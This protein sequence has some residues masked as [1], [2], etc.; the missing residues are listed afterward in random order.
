MKGWAAAIVALFASTGSALAQPAGFTVKD[1]YWTTAEGNSLYVY[2]SASL[3][4]AR[5]LCGSGCATAM[6]ESPQWQAV[7]V[8]P[9][10]L[11]S[12]WTAMPHNAGAQLAYR[13][14]PL[15]TQTGVTDQR[16]DTDRWRRLPAV[17]SEFHE[18]DDPLLAALPALSTRSLVAPD[19]P[20]ASLRR[21]ESG[22][23]GIQMCV[24][25][26]GLPLFPKIVRSSGFA[27][28]D[29]ATLEWAW[30][31]LRFTPAR[32]NDRHVGVCGFVHEID[33][34]ISEPASQSQ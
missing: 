1:G 29:T 18:I 8:D 30:R 5:T 3:P 12:P 27:R 16:F 10:A 19:Y 34:Q 11:A 13:R 31:R 28:L 25:D 20:A 9:D 26:Q 15:F 21:K 23:V 22:V 14:A 4:D 7:L 32:V 6:G 17:E 24:N 33:W 2:A